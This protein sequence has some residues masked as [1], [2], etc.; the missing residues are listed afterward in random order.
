MS[1]DQPTATGAEYVLKLLFTREEDAWRVYVDA[2]RMPRFLRACFDADGEAFPVVVD[3]EDLERHMKRRGADFKKS[4]SK[5]GDVQLEAQ[6][7][8]ATELSLWLVSALG[9]GFREPARNEQDR[10]ARG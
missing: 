7:Q 2:P 6:G 5:Y 9:S 4:L 3:F 8:A 1:A 10:A